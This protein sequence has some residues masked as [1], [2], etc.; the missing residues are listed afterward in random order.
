MIVAPF[1]NLALYHYRVPGFIKIKTHQKFSLDVELNGLQFRCYPY[2]DHHD[3]ST[4]RGIVFEK[5]RDTFKF[6][7]SVTASGAIVDVGAN[8]GAISI[9]SY[10]S[11][12]RQKEHPRRPN[13][14]G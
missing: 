6:L 14:L 8:A 13:Q 9:P 7:P 12:G 2:Q 11:G 4:F 1:L 3:L 5:E 10:L